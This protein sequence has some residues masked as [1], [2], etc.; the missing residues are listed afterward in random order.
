MTALQDSASNSTDTHGQ[1]HIGPTVGHCPLPC[2]CTAPP[3]YLV[4]ARPWHLALCVESCDCGHERDC[5]THVQVVLRVLSSSTQSCSM[6]VFNQKIRLIRTLYSLT[7][8]GAT[9]CT[10]SCSHRHPQN[11]RHCMYTAMSHPRTKRRQCSGDSEAEGCDNRDNLGVAGSQL[12]PLKRQRVGTQ[13]LRH[14]L[15]TAL[16]LTSKPTTTTTTTTALLLSHSMDCTGADKDVGMTEPDQQQPAGSCD[17]FTT[18]QCVT[19]P[20]LDD[21]LQRCVFGSALAKLFSHTSRTP[22]CVGIRL[23]ASSSHV[24][25]LFVPAPASY[26]L[27]R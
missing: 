11:K 26:D 12:Q 15:A 27:H 3:D 9:N 23:V 16:A 20:H 17:W 13:P 5:F 1:L 8:P 25:T 24:Y 22:P 7:S 19:A 6:L 14:M 21:A 4:Y 2:T 10:N 18:L